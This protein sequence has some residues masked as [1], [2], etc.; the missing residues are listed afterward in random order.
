MNNQYIT[1]SIFARQ[2]GAATKLS[3]NE[4][5]E[6]NDREH[7]L[8][9]SIADRQRQLDAVMAMEDWYKQNLQATELLEDT[10]AHHNLVNKQYLALRG[11]EM[12]LERFDSIQ[13]FRPLYEQVG[14]CRR[15]IDDIIADLDQAFAAVR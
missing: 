3:D 8:L 6:I 7:H 10:T 13:E 15:V 2:A 5:R 4:L 9:V 1:E 12:K 11:E 14:E